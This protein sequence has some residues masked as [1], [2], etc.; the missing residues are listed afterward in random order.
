MDTF[1]CPNRL[2]AEWSV[3]RPSKSHVQTD[4]RSLT[5]FFKWFCLCPYSNSSSPLVNEH[6][7][8]NSYCLCSAI[9][10]LNALPIIQLTCCSNM[11]GS[12]SIFWTIFRTML[13]RILFS[14][15]LSLVDKTRSVPWSV[16]SSKSL[17]P[18][19]TILNHWKE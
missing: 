6:S 19:I 18:T 4:I 2:V 3:D 17:G 10:L 7:K 14:K 8:G 16:S 9:N 5:E 11:I 13:W 12:W 1:Y 15:P